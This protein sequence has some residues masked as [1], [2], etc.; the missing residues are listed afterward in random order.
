MIGCQ[1]SRLKTVDDAIQ[2]IFN[3]KKGNPSL[4]DEQYLDINSPV[5]AWKTHPMHNTTMERKFIHALL[6]PYGNHIPSQSDMK[7]IVKKIFKVFS[8]YP[9]LTAIHTDHFK[10]PHIH[11]LIHPRNILTNK[12]WQQTSQNLKEQKRSLTVTLKSLGLY[13]ISQDQH[14]N[15]S[16][17]DIK[18]DTKADS[19]I[20]TTN[21]NRYITYQATNDTHFHTIKVYD[22]SSFN[23]SQILMDLFTNPPKPV[24]YDFIEN[25]FDSLDISIM[26]EPKYVKRIK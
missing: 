4:W 22:E 7:I 18:Q 20:T 21:D 26:E 12:V 17:S 6:C 14:T 9:L 15:Q 23:S 16:T 1:S 8:E 5:A 2:Y 19:C 10:S 25:G 13:G 3:P 11:M 24:I